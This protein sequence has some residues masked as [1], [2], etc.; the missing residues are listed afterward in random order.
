MSEYIT[1]DGCDFL[2]LLKNLK[3]AC[4]Q[5]ERDVTALDLE[6]LCGLLL[7]KNMILLDICA[8]FSE[9]F[10]MSLFS[11]LSSIDR[12]ILISSYKCDGFCGVC[13]PPV[14]SNM[15]CFLLVVNLALYLW[16]DVLISNNI[17][18]S[19]QCSVCKESIQSW[20]AKL[21]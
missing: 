12:E 7:E 13:N 20:I 19:A 15:V 18:D 10:T 21:I 16:P 3:E 17:P 5:L 9:I 2:I 6:N 14:S 1:H 8:Q 11:D 4:Q